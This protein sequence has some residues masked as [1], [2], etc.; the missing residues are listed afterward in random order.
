MAGE[1]A[2]LQGLRWK[3]EGMVWA[4]WGG[5]A[6]LWIAAGLTLVTGYDY[7]RKAM[8]YLRESR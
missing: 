6:L 1:V 7:L 2:Y 3:F 8:P 5:L 4:G